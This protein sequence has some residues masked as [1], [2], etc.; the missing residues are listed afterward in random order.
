MS[1]GHLLPLREVAGLNLDTIS[2][3]PLALSRASR[4]ALPPLAYLRWPLVAPNCAKRI[5]P[6]AETLRA[7]KEARQSTL[8]APSR[9]PGQPFLPAQRSGERHL[10]YLLG[11]VCLCSTI[12]L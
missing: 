3:P 10:Y 2:Q 5:N 11:S 12:S 6:Q 4:P 1:I 8:A 7:S 9:R